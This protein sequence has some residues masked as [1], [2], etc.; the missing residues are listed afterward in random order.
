MIIISGNKDKVAS[1]NLYMKANFRS[2]DL[3]IDEIQEIDVEK[4]ARKKAMS[5]YANVGEA[6]LVDDTGLYI[7]YLNGFP[8]AL[9]TWMVK[10]VGIEMIAKMCS[11][12]GARMETVI[13]VANGEGEIQI[14]RGGID[15]KIADLPQGSG[16]F[17]FDAVFI[18][19]G[20]TKTLAQMSIEEKSQFDPRNVA[21]NLL[22]ADSVE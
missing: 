13:G 2:Y 20:E 12:A 9:V 11:G 15:G 5:A 3:E 14:Y 4:V 21:L 8:G 16:G 10:S 19:D 18:P 6:C 17:G 1:I 22:M 7:D